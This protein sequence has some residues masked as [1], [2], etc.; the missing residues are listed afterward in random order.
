MKLTLVIGLVAAGLA[1]AALL[2]WLQLRKLRREAFIREYA[3]PPGLLYKLQRKHGFG[4]KESALVAEGLRTFFLAYLK[5]GKRYIAMPSQVADDLWHEFILFT[6]AYDD[7]CK[8]AFG[9]FLHHTPAVALA[10]DRLASNAGLRRVWYWCCKEENINVARPTRLPLLFA[11]DKKLRIP[12][13]YVY[14]PDCAQLRRN[15]V[16]G[17]QCGGDF[18]S[19]SIDGSTSGIDGGSGDS[20]AGA[21]SG[22]DSG[23]GDGG[24]C[25]GGCGGGGD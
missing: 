9:D 11:L 3:W 7:F 18:T 22:G 24:S 4:R 13:G 1:L 19:S 6:R 20:G 14:E 5:G 25:G 23:G 15:G 21:D 12:G 2:L 17:S 10:P 8:T 16:A